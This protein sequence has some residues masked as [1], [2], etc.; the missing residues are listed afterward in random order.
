VPEVTQ[1]LTAQG[2]EPRT[3]SPAEFGASIRSETAKWAQ[4]VKETGIRA[5]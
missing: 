1:R 4:L 2:A 5:E 3:Q